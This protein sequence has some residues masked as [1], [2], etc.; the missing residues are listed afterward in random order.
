MKISDF[1]GATVW[2]LSSRYKFAEDKV[3]LRGSISGFRATLHQIYSKITILFRSWTRD[4]SK[5]YY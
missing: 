2:K 5:W 3:T 4:S 1:G